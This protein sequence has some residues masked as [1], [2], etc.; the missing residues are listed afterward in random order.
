MESLVVDAV[1]DRFLYGLQEM[2]EDILILAIVMVILTVYLH[3]Q[4]L[5]PHKVDI[6][7]GTLKNVRLR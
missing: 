1:K 4:Y 2:V 7:L 3:Y 6:N 5:V